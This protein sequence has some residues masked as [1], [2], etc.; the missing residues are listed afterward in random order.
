MIERAAEIWY[1]KQLGAWII[2]GCCIVAGAAWI[3]WIAVQ[4]W[5]Q[6]RKRRHDGK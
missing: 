2:L 5:K 3:I 6:K 1:Y 4:E